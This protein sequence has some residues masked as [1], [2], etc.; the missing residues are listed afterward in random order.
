M[1]FEHPQLGYDTS[2]ESPGA[3][4][5]D[6]VARGLGVDLR[7]P[8]GA[9]RQCPAIHAP[10]VTSLDHAPRIGEQGSRLEGRVTYPAVRV[11]RL[12]CIAGMENVEV[13]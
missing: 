13:L 6:V 10:R 7:T 3:D 1:G 2:H 4:A 9:L 8:P 12:P 11:Y 5:I